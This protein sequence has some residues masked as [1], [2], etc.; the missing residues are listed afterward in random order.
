MQGHRD[1]TDEIGLL[2][3]IRST[4]IS[5]WLACHISGLV[6]TSLSRWIEKDEDKMLTGPMRYKSRRVPKVP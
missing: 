3:S 4:H 5:T 1:V 2:N 6:F